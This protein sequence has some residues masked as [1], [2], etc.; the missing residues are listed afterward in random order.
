MRQMRLLRSL[1]ARKDYRKWERQCRRGD[2]RR[3]DEVLLQTVA[4]RWLDSDSAR[5]ARFLRADAEIWKRLHAGADQ[6]LERHFECLM[7]E[8]LPFLRDELQWDMWRLEA[9]VRVERLFE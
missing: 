3:E 2:G 1:M 8:T 5:R 9:V 7:H 4:S 6:Q